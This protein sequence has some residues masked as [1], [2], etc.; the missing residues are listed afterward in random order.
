M[1]LLKSSG[2]KIDSYRLFAS[3]INSYLFHYYDYNNN[4]LRVV[5]FHISNWA[6]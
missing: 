4:P 5:H 1:L 3:G 2:K 6:S